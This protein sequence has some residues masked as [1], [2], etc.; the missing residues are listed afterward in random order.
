MAARSTPPAGSAHSATA[1][2]HVAP[3]PPQPDAL[4]GAVSAV[5]TPKGADD[6]LLERAATLGPAKPIRICAGWDY[7]DI[8]DGAYRLHLLHAHL[9]V[10]PRTRRA[11]RARGGPQVGAL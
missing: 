5:Y 3:A 11:H 10:G 2:R 6:A 1:N 4:R 8:I 7:L 9:A